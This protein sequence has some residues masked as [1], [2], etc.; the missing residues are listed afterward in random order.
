MGIPSRNSD[1]ISTIS[2]FCREISFALPP[3]M[4]NDFH[5]LACIRIR[6]GFKVEPTIGVTDRA[7]ESQEGV[8]E[9]RVRF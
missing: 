5:T 2:L 1:G 3:A 6:I 4:M 7:A 9:I 8:V